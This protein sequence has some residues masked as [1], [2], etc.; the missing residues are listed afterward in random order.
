MIVVYIFIALG[1]ITI[2]IGLLNQGKPVKPVKE[3]FI[4]NDDF[5]SVFDINTTHLGGH[6]NIEIDDRVAF[7]IKENGVFCMRLPIGNRQGFKHDIIDPKTIIKCEC[8]TE[9]EIKKSVTFT[10]LLALGIFSLAFKKQSKV[11]N[12]YMVFDYKLNG[13]PIS[14]IFQ[15]SEGQKLTKLVYKINEAMINSNTKVMTS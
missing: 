5:E 13:I 3:T 14:C 15:S 11:T 9:Q 7:Q 12:F 10:R 6:P 1:I 2:I 4:I 8:K